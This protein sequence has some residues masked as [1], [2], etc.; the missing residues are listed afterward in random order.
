MKNY[1][2]YLMLVIVVSINALVGCASY[3]NSNPGYNSSKGT[4]TT[5][6]LTRHGDRDTLSSVLNEKGRLRADALVKAVSDYK[7]TAIYCPDKKRNINTAKPTANHYGVE[8]KTVGEE[9]VVFDV[10]NTMLS[11]HSGEVVLWVG[12]TD[13]L[14]EIYYELGGKGESPIKYGDLFIMEIKESGYPNVIKRRYGPL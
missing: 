6:I 5:I 11:K 12:N 9:P 2:L 8:I 3:N 14:P 4:S 10:L 7:L 1:S 13:N